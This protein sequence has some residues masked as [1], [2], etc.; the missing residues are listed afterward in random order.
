[1]KI[2]SSSSNR[3]I[4]TLT[5]FMAGF[6]PPPA[7]DKTIPLRWQAFPFAVDNEARILSIDPTACASYLADYMKVFR[8]IEADPT[9][10]SW[11]AED[12]AL[13]DKLSAFVGKPLTTFTDAFMA[14]ETIRTQQFLAPPTPQWVL[15]ALVPLRRY[16]VRY[17]DLFHE[18]ELMRKVR[19]GPMLTQVVDNM[20]AVAN[21]NATAKKVILQS[22]HDLSLSSMVAVLDVKDQVP[23]IAAYSDTIAIEL[24]Q[25]GVNEPEVQIYYISSTTAKKLHIPLRVP[26]CGTPCKL[27][28][29]TNLVSKYLVRD[30]NA[31]CKV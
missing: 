7:N 21:N 24:H 20:V 14:A 31:M 25:N 29:F 30:Y 13:L 27:S 23:P 4:A 18:T 3:C 6:M 5:S 2:T 8:R 11:L 16:M 15:D 9:V 26:N 10:R 28:T 12:K 1:M 22:A 19:G 17:F